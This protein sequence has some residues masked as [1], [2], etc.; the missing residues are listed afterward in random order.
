M[1]NNEIEK[2]WKSYQDFIGKT[3]PSLK[4]KCEKLKEYMELLREWGEKVN[5]VGDLDR[6][7]LLQK[8]IIDCTPLTRHL[9]Q[10]QALCDVGS[11]AGFPGVVVSILKPL[12]KID[13]VESRQRRC[14]FLREV[15]R[16]LQL[17]NI[18][19]HTTR[20]ESMVKASERKWDHAVSRA[21]FSWPRWKEVGE[22]MVMDDGFVWFMVNDRQRQEMANASITFAKEECYEVEKGVVHHLLGW[23]KT[24]HELV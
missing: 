17:D 14:A 12:V 23:K 21:V 20:I 8:H 19:I 2:V 5:L 7:V 11:G 1:K 3:V 10:G 22:Q 15:K 4:E 13:L 24:G 6:S 18:T 16:Q 9:K